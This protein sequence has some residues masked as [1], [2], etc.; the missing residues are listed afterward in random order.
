MVFMRQVQELEELLAPPD[1]A[2]VAWH[3]TVRVVCHGPRRS[4]VY[5]REGH[6]FK[7]LFSLILVFQEIRNLLTNGFRILSCKF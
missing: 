4:E 3:L 2:A 1:P 5:V 7:F 6:M